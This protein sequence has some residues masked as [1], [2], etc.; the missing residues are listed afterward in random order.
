[1]AYFDTH[2]AIEKIIATGILKGTA[3]ATA[4]GLLS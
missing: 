4:E 3:E 2:R 1:M